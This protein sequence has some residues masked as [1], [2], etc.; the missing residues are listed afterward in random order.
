MD[1]RFDWVRH[2]IPVCLAALLVAASA[3]TAEV[4][5]QTVPA[6]RPNI[7]W[8]TRE[9]T[10]PKSLVSTWRDPPFRSGDEAEQSQSRAVQRILDAFVAESL[11]AG[12]IDAKK[13]LWQTAGKGSASGSSMFP[14][15]VD[16]RYLRFLVEGLYRVAALGGNRQYRAAA[17]AHVRF[18]ARIMR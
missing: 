15:G 5:A 14:G 7:L 13:S 6:D 11:P 17:D 10:S 8:I 9:D 12:G 4:S 2:I 1:I 16:V 18:M 3:T